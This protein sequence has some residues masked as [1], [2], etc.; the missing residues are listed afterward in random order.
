[1]KMGRSDLC[2][3]DG[4]KRLFFGG[5]WFLDSIFGYVNVIFCCFFFL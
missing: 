3:K 2:D 4:V 1:M 5:E